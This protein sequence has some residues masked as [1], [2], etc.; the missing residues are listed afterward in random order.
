MT[1]LLFEVSKDLMIEPV[2]KTKNLWKGFD[3]QTI[4]VDSCSLC[5]KEKCCEKYKK[6]GKN[7]KKCPRVEIYL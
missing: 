2:C 1:E 5:K 3:L 6:K 7:C 4:N